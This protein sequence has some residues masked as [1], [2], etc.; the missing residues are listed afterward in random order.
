MVKKPTIR[1]ARW[2]IWTCVAVFAAMAPGGCGAQRASAD[3]VFVNGDIVTVNADFDRREAV[4]VKDGRFVA[5][6]D[7]AEILALAGAETEVFDLGG[8]MVIPG[9]IDNHNHVIR[10]TEYWANEARLDG[11]A[12]RTEAIR[13]LR[14]KHAAL[15]PGEWLMSLGGWT[16]DQFAD[17]QRGF[18]RLELDEIAPDRPTFVQVQYSHVYVNT[19]WME[20]VGLSTSEPNPEHKLEAYVERGEDGAATGRLMGGFPAIVA[21][22]DYFPAIPGDNQ[23]AGVREMERTLNSLGLTSVYDPGGLGLRPE[24][25]DRIRALNDSDGL[26]VRFFHTLWLGAPRTREEVDRLVAAM[27]EEAPR[28]GDAWMRSVAVGEVL[29]VPFHWDGVVEPARQSPEDMEIGR[30]ILSA[31]AE[32][33]WPVQIHAIQSQ[34]I[35]GVLD[36]VE[37]VNETRPVG[38]LRWSITHADN[39][40]AAEIVR[41]EAL[42]V[43]LQLRSEPVVGGREAVIE[44]FGGEAA[45]HMPPLRLVEDSGVAYGFGTDGTKAGQI[46]PFVTLWW[47][48]AGK[49]L[50]GALQLAETLTREE[51]LIAHTRSNAYLLFEENQLGQISPGYLADMVVLDRDYLSAPVDEIRDIRPVATIVGGD[52]VYG[53]L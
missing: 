23:R 37:A 45:A 40:G 19:T 20:I 6:G 30:K 46:N 29:Y 33:R 42:G 49:E 50:G 13:R 7:D 14:E 5:V 11:A 10:A 43:T 27:R 52:I 9:L 51:A 39:I 47:A 8:R 26:T 35:A 17:E 36:V 44:A 25:Y 24:S 22:L 4:A 41:A 16:E 38:D 3:R 15:A 53:G 2:F 12:T 28:Q 21:A 48:V 32:S 34:T 1:F 18:S 31:A